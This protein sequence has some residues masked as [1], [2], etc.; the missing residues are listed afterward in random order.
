[1]YFAYLSPAEAEAEAG[2]KIVNEIIDE[3]DDD[4]GDESKYEHDAIMAAKCAT[5]CRSIHTHTCKYLDNRQQ[6]EG[7]RCSQNQRQDSA[8]SIALA[9]CAALNGVAAL[10]LP[11]TLSHSPTLSLFSLSLSL[12]VCVCTRTRTRQRFTAECLPNAI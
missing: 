11:A 4:D 2:D 12:F 8:K 6:E 3:D 1:M 5:R 10:A 7:R 9:P